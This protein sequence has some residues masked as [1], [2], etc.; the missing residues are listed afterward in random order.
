ML[1]FALFLC[2]TGRMRYIIHYDIAAIVMLL[3]IL[4]LIYTR[5]GMNK[6]SN[7]VF[8]FVVIAE[9]F[10]AVTDI[11]SSYYISFPDRISDWG[12]DFWCYFF[13]GV[14][15]VVPLL[16]VIYIICLT[17]I[18]KRVQWYKWFGAVLPSLISLGFLATNFIH[19]GV[20]FFDENNAYRRG[21][22]MTV[23]YTDA[24]IS[25]LIA[26]YVLIRYRK[27]LSRYKI[28]AAIACE[29]L[30]VFPIVVQIFFPYLLIE[31]FFQSIGMMGLLFSVENEDER[32]NPITGAY[33]RFAFMR[34]VDGS[35]HARNKMSVLTVKIYNISYYNSTFGITFMNQI[36]RDM[37]GWLRTLHKNAI[38]YDFYGGHFALVVNS[39]N[40]EIAKELA[41]KIRERFDVEWSK[42]PVSVVF[43]AQVGV[44][45]VPDEV[46]T[47]DR[48][49]LFIDAPTEDSSGRS[50]LMGSDQIHYY[51]R[52]LL[53][54]Q[55][56]TEALDNNSLEV[57]FQPVWDRASRKVR[58]AEALVRLVDR[59]IGVIMPEE[60]V[61]IAER[62]GSIMEVGRQVMDKVCAFYSENRLELHGIDHIAVNLSVLQCMNRYLPQMIQEILAMHNMLP[63]HI[64][65]EITESAAAGN[66]SAMEKTVRE[67]AG[68]GFTL[69]LDDYGTGYS[70]Y[71]YMFTMPFKIIKI[72]KSIL[73]SALDTQNVRGQESAMVLLENTV[74]MLRQMQYKVVVE[75]VE[76]KEQMMLLSGFSS[77]YMQGFFFSEPL[78]GPQF[79]H[80]ADRFNSGDTVLFTP[81]ERNADARPQQSPY[82][83]PQ[84]QSQPQSQSARNIVSF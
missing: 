38:C 34:D 60:F 66:K 51:Q 7:W 33:N 42:D 62:N 28:L 48:L 47:V 43:P 49:M 67:L 2:Y 75:G 82:A 81:R 79:L 70:N 24:G 53:I 23:M 13:L 26:T 32:T 41:E 5:K 19:S 78:P 1:P 35:I 56:L 17:G 83:A 57:Y 80:F 59:E 71:S 11:I 84:A 40:K 31:M 36:L 25:L 10:C 77:D 6:S 21:P 3:F 61:P 74:R 73:W 72:D 12:R 54:E 55:K 64:T 69:A 65:L 30:S 58:S 14:H 8:C 18:Q 20:F 63:Q 76:T 68:S 16:L 46:S 44:L 50:Q 22:F 29:I 45:Q 9:L 37:T 52:S 27:T 39:T 15:N 4:F